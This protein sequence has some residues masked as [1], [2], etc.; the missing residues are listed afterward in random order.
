MRM[1]TKAGNIMGRRGR[2]DFMVG[3]VLSVLISSYS[4]RRDEHVFPIASKV[5]TKSTKKTKG[6]DIFLLCTSTNQMP[7]DITKCTNHSILGNRSIGNRTLD[8]T[9]SFVYPYKM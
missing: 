2:R 9:I 1:K 7:T 8:D 6:L 5:Y 3:C 4:R